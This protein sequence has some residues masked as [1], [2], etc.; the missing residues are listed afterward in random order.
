MADQERNAP[1][2]NLTKP[3]DGPESN[4]S[5]TANYL[6]ETSAEMAVPA[7]YGR[8]NYA[9]QRETNQA[10]GGTGVGFAALILSILSLFVAPVLF[11][12]VGIVLGF[13]ARRRGATGLGSWAVGIGAIS[14]VL[15]MFIL[16]FF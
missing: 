9:E 1:R 13:V 12:A 3:D 14:I 8:G 16:P 4:Q 5:G 15:G 2:V 11:G 6:E 7:S 10:A